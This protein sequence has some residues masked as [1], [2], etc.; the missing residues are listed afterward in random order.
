MTRADTSAVLMGVL[1][2]AATHGAAQPGPTEPVESAEVVVT[3]T[4]PA[5]DRALADTRAVASP[6]NGQLAR[7]EVPVCPLALGLARAQ[8]E[9][10]ETRIRHIAR[11]VNVRTAPAGCAPNLVVFAA[12]N[13]RRLLDLLH[14]RRSLLFAS[15]EVREL[16][17]L[18]R[19]P[20][21]CWTWRSVTPKRR[22]GGPVEMISEFQVAGGP[23]RHVPGRA[24]AVH[25]AHLG[26]LTRPDR[27]DIDVSFVVL[28]AQ[29]L[30]G[31]TLGQIGDYAGVVALGAIRPGRA[32]S[33]TNGFILTMF[34]D[35]GAERT[36]PVEATDFDLAYLTGLYAGEAGFSSDRKSAEIAAGIRRSAGR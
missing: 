19:S 26:R 12:E 13:G 1:L 28:D 8:A 16:A 11:R 25:N 30:A 5:H 4:R 31:L 27:Q 36:P 32:G 7:Y 24:Y 34:Q 6:V 14:R 9:V 21:P 3:G 15:L 29:A 22:D 33:L 2:F 18:L 17:A 23:P 35:V 20:G 10:I